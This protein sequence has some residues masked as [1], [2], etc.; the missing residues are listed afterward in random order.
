MKARLLALL[1]VAVLI[2]A[3]C[4]SDGGGGKED[5]DGDVDG[6][7]VR[8]DGDV[9]GDDVEGVDPPAEDVPFDDSVDLPPAEDIP[10]ETGLVSSVTDHGVTWTF[11]EPVLAGQ[12]ITGD[13]Y[14]VCP[15]TVT[16]IDPPPEGGRNGSVLNI[17]PVQDQTGFDDRTVEGRFEES[18]R[19]YPPISMVPGD[20]L[21]S[22][23]SV[24][25]P[26]EVDNW[27]R[28]GNGER[29][30][31][32]V[33]SVSILTCLAE[34][35]PADAFRPS[36]ADP[37][38]TIYRL[39]Q[40]NRALLPVLDPPGPVDTATLQTFA[41]RIIRPWVDNLFYAF[42]AQVE[43][44]AMYGRET[45]RVAG[46]SSL[47]VMLNLPDDQKPI[48]EKLLIGV[49]QHGIDLWG[50]VKAGYPGWYA[51][52]GHGSGRKWPI[53]MAGMLLGDT[54]MAAPSATYP[55]TR[56][57]EDMH[58][59]FTDDLPY[60]PA[61]CGAT[62]VY[63]GH[64]GWWRGAPVSSDPAWGPY[65]HLAPDEWL[66][67]IGE[68]YRRCCTSL[69]WVGQALAARLMNAQS[70][71]GHDAF[72]AYVDRWMDPTG[73]AEYTQTIYDMTGLD[74]RADWQAHGQAW[75]DFINEMWAAYR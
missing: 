14:V 52:G 35:A 37:Y 41:D 22:S 40:V 5:A 24:E 65:E 72:F 6:D 12:F 55:D 69:A 44:M 26:G 75:D 62:V 39:S 31:S 15:V 67:P 19:S 25:T 51:H 36:Y 18:L 70:S 48:Q 9:P 11:S 10:G 27:L 60:G 13:W 7:D 21:A 34:P 64:M 53:I 54:A 71:W 4:C 23:I 28:E 17:P 66:D 57:G 32:P 68:N 2:L 16:A 29:S 20:R 61:W 33:W 38:A 30:D 46:I 43:Y 58:T 3:P 56:F 42:D 73:D 59:A 74:Y 8:P 63:T 1:P 47:L 45:G 50:L 49:I